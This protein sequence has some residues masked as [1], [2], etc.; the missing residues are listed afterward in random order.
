VFK[1]GGWLNLKEREGQ[2]VLKGD[3]ERKLYVEKVVE[4]RGGQ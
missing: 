2:T 4:T 3:R 1:G